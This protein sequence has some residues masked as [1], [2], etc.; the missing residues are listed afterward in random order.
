[1]VGDGHNDV[2]VG[3]A[4][5][6]PIVALSYGYTRVPLEELEP[7]VIIDTFSEVLEAVEKLAPSP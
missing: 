7:D 5:E 2:L 6:V 1:M 3:K 4:A